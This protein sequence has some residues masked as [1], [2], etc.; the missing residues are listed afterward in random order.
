MKGRF[1]VFAGALTL[2]AGCS[3][4]EPPDPEE[5]LE[6][7]L[8]AWEEG[9]YGEMDGVNDEAQEQYELIYGDLE[10]DV[11]LTYEPVDWEE[12][13]IDLEELEDTT[14]T[15]DVEMETFAGPLDYTVEVPLE[16]TRTEEN[17][18]GEWDVLWQPEHLLL[19][20]QDIND[21]FRVTYEEPE[22]GEIFDRSG[23]ALAV[24]GEIYEAA[25]VPDRTESMEETAAAFAG[26][27]GLEEESVLESA[28]AYPD[29]PDWAAPVQRLAVS[30]PRAEELLEI[31][32]VQLDRTAGREYPLGRAAGHLIGH[33]GAI[34]AEELEDRNGY[35][36]TSEIGKFGLEAAME[37]T[38][39]GT[40]GIQIT[41]ED[42]EGEV[43]EMLI[44]EAAEPGEDVT[45][46]IDAGQQERASSVLDGES[47]AAV[48]TDPATGGVLALASTPSYDSNL[49]YLGLP[50]PTAAELDTVDLLF[51]E[52]FRR[53]YSPG[54][55]FK[56]VTAMIA[57][58]NDVIDPGEERTIEGSQWQPDDSWGGYQVTRVNDSVSQV[59]LET[60]MT[61]SDNIYFAQTALEIGAET[62][63]A[64]AEA[65]GFGTEW[66]L[67]LPAASGQLAND[68]LEEEI[69][70]AD[71]GYGQG[72]VLAS[73]LQMAG[74]Y[75]IF[76]DGTLR[77]PVL[78]DGETAETA[79]PVSTET[80]D[81]VRETLTSVV[82]DPDGTAYRP[83]R[84]HS[85]Q[86]IGKTGTAELKADQT[87]EDGS[88]TGW[89]ASLNDQYVLVVML[90]DADSGQ[91][92]EAADR[93]WAGIGE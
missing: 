36:S 4:E 48:L 69:L 3:Q 51:E 87:V 55:I 21:T 24:N 68:G 70:L 9:R 17:E 61:L 5:A 89:F 91:A 46:T 30:D 27:M 71:T 56:P 64:D 38:L 7:Y 20:M 90:Q 92:V 47:G 52:R 45:L 43:R 13:E 67:A 16:K 58:E 77:Q 80:L 25:V 2:A 49:R 66:D 1:L 78:L 35:Q 29:N 14:Y 26:I 12:E 74:I 18:R 50:D 57:L 22:R 84:G 32:G 53:A 63:L 15:V 59:D 81:I 65:F 8:S 19:G 34:T 72:Q 75:S 42:G 86:L 54:S 40:P 41:V 83:E 6:A 37:D 44:S 39:R 11:S 62:F 82:Q 28:Q 73:P 33:I 60:A 93:I 85:Q 23:D 31:P 10:A 88:E 79:E 76:H